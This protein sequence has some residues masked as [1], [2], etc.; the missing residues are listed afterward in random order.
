MERITVVSTDAHVSPPYSVYRDYID[1]SYRDRLD[2]LE[3]E[4]KII[5]AGSNVNRGSILRP[6]PEVIDDR[7]LLTAE[8]Y[9]ND[10]DLK[11]RLELL[12]GEGIAGETVLAGT[13]NHAMPF[14]YEMNTPY[15]TDVRAA[16]TRAYHRW[17]A[18]FVGES[19]G[20]LFG[21]AYSI[22][23]PDIQ[24]LVD[25]VRYVA[26]RGFVSMEVPGFVPDPCLP[27]LSS[28]EFDPFWAACAER[29]IVLLVHAGWGHR[30]GMITDAF[31]QLIAAIEEADGNFDPMK[32]M[33]APQNDKLRE[34]FASL[35]EPPSRVLWHLLFGGVFDRHPNLK[36][37][38]CEVGA[39]WIPETLRYLDEK[40][41][42]E[43]VKLQHTVEEYF[44]RH[45]AVTATAIRLCEVEMRDEIGIDRLMFG[46]DFPHPES[47]FPNTRQWLAHAF[48]GVEEDDVRKILGENAIRI[49]NLDRGPLDEA[50]ARIGPT[51]AEL[52][53]G[54]ELDERVLTSFDNRNKYRQ[55][56][57]P[58]D[59]GLIDEYLAPDL[60]NV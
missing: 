3:A 10:S 30:Q 19:Q 26:D 21:H 28:K 2:D 27:A 56:A 17:L 31:T 36:L 59:T 15:P 34:V 23:S 51:P 29:G 7:G 40:L 18:D 35:L 1:P 16:G 50:A 44:A 47:T 48:R 58:V 46:A 11:R 25:E 33:A 55:P 8:E 39:A 38:F 22:A 49:F 42:A 54:I 57:Q 32:M 14:F 5:R 52:A 53:A 4:E 20:R 41:A 9:R 37:S 13:S 60:A 24:D 6:G 43:G 12:D 45:C